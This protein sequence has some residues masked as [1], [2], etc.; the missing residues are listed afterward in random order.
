MCDTRD[1]SAKIPLSPGQHFLAYLKRCV[2]GAFIGLIVAGGIYMCH[3]F[4]F[5]QQLERWGNDA[6]MQYYSHSQNNASGA[7][8]RV[9]SKV[10]VIVLNS[11]QKQQTVGQDGEGTVGE[12][13]DLLKALKPFEVK[14][15]IFD[16]EFESSVPP[17]IMEE[18]RRELVA[19]SKTKIVALPVHAIPFKSDGRGM[20]D[21]WLIMPDGLSSAAAPGGFQRIL[22]NLVEDADGVVRR[23]APWACAVPLNGNSWTATPTLAFALKN[24]PSVACPEAEAARQS[25]LFRIGSDQIFKE[26]KN[27]TIPIR[28]WTELGPGLKSN[29][30]EYKYLLKDAILVVGQIKWDD[31]YRTPLGPMPGVLVQANA[32]WTSQQPFAIGPSDHVNTSESAIG[33]IMIVAATLAMLPILQWLFWLLLIALFRQVQRRIGRNSLAECPSIC[34]A[35][36]HQPIDKPTMQELGKAGV[37]LIV[38][39]MGIAILVSILLIVMGPLATKFA[40][41]QLLAGTVVGSF[42]PI[43]AVGL[44]ALIELAGYLLGFCYL[45]VEVLWLL[46]GRL[47]ATVD[48]LSTSAKDPNLSS[49]VAAA[50][51]LFLFMSPGTAAEVAGKL[52]FESV[53]SN[54][55]YV[56]R[57]N[58]PIPVNGDFVLRSY[59]T[60]QIRSSKAEVKIDLL[61][62]PCR[63][64]QQ[65]K[66]PNATYLVSPPAPCSKAL[67]VHGFFEGLLWAPPE[68]TIRRGATSLTRNMAG[69]PLAM[70]RA[71]MVAHIE[72][73]QE[74]AVSISGVL[75]PLPSLDTPDAQLLVTMTGLAL[76]WAGGTPPYEISAE[77]TDT[78]EVLRE[79]QSRDP[80]IWWPNWRMP[81]ERVTLTIADANG[82]ELRGKLVPAYALPAGKSV[83]SSAD[84]ID[85]FQ[86]GVDWRLECLRRLAAL[87]A[88]DTLAAQALAA[89]RLSARDQ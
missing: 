4:A 54:E 29:P 39:A 31:T 51:L 12:L 71:A 18:L 86:A 48:R 50:L 85:L 80:Y 77:I 67:S 2:V 76:T 61:P 70:D 44:E 38:C 35:P 52:T 68:E 62:L 23:V 88:S 7:T 13:I 73:G 45:L 87:A 60:V 1:L 53:I 26:N 27:V 41:N 81:H 16:L 83:D 10:V 65:L 84:V 37:E 3:N 5:I 43:F 58:Y 89:I 6:A 78:G 33:E 34:W 36:E 17:A 74:L 24:P 15:L 30:D 64:E 49:L 57:D 32:V 22:A 47:R 11:L 28:S 25:I 40:A 59:D 69:T 55:V 8:S 82:R 56:L 14:A 79:Q 20:N 42:I 46:P 9:S 75:R 72:T 21:R 19:Q 63:Q 66:G